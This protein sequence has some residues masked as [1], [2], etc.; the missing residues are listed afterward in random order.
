MAATMPANP[1]PIHTT[2]IRRHSSIEKSG[3]VG[4]SVEAA[5]VAGVFWAVDMGEKYNILPCKRLVWVTSL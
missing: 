1:A 2:L 3:A 4:A 5:M